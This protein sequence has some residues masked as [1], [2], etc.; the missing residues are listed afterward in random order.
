MILATASLPDALRPPE[1]VLRR[2]ATS[3]VETLR[4]DP[5]LGA[6]VW[7][8][9]G[10]ATPHR[11]ENLADRWLVTLSVQSSHGIG[12]ALTAEP[13]I[14]FPR[15]ALAVIDPSVVHWLVPSCTEMA[16]DAG[17]IEL[18]LWVGLQWEIPKDG[19]APGRVR[20]LVARLDGTPVTNID[21][22]YADWA[23]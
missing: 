4:L 14:A 22:R 23:A 9:C 15:G 10:T 3:A 20:E 1:P 17:R 7:L 8:W 13:E 2:P 11:D 19:R 21:H 6:T 12:D 18:P 16:D 5:P